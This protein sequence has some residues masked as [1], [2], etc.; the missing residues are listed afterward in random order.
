MKSHTLKLTKQ[1]L[2]SKVCTIQKICNHF[3][4]LYTSVPRND[5]RYC[6]SIESV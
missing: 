5:N 4:T 3:T 2:I 6:T 1:L